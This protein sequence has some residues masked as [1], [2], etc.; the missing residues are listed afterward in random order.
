[1]WDDAGALLASGDGID[2]A[3]LFACGKGK[4]RIDLS[5]RGRPGPYSLLVRPERWRD[6]AFTAH[7]LAASRMLSRAA[8]GAGALHE[9]NPSSVR[10]AVLDAG[11]QYVQSTTIPAAQCLRVAAGVEG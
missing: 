4:A 7:P 6:A 9:G 2:G 5:A 3:T 10:H 8:S 1:A 11:H